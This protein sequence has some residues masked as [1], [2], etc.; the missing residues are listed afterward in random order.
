MIILWVV[1]MM[2]GAIALAPIPTAHASG[3]TNDVA[4]VNAAGEDMGTQL[5][6]RVHSGEATWSEGW[7]ALG[8][9]YIFKDPIQVEGT[10]NLILRDSPNGTFSLIAEKGI[11][12]KPNS[13]LIIWAQKE[14]TGRVQAYG[15][16]N[17]AGISIH[18]DASL[19]INGGNIIV[20]GGKCAP[21]LGSCGSKSGVI[22][23]NGGRVD[24]TGGH[25]LEGRYITYRS[26]RDG[27]E[28]STGPRCAC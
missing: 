24:A 26:A 10:A 3:E 16:E 18:E 27:V 2:I 23:I 8:S 14:G 21:G 12:L 17:Y 25:K 6:K 20:S 1:A 4:Y 13:H 7:Y 15:Q 22:T 11:I 28:S 19:T 9:T 5:C